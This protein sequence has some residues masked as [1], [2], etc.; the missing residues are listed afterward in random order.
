MLPFTFEDLNERL[1]KIRAWASAN[2]GEINR[3]AICMGVTLRLTPSTSEGDASVGDVAGSDKILTDAARIA[4]GPRGDYKNQLFIRASELLPRVQRA[5]GLA[6]VSG[7]AKVVW[8]R[9]EGSK[10]VI[11]I[12]NCYPTEG[13]KRWTIKGVYEPTSGDHWDLFDGI[14]MVAEKAW[15]R[16]NHHE[17][18]LH[19]WRARSSR[20]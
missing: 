10:G 18:S 5:Y 13:D 1:P 14:M 6:D 3:C 11:Y 8:P 19:F 9:V 4:G 17:D 15:I 12:E 20:G 7:P 2:F 16:N